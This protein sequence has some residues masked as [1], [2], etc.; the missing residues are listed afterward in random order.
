[1][2]LHRRQL[3]AGAAAA[4]L[5]VSCASTESA[6]ADRAPTDSAPAPA[7][8]PA[9]A[10]LPCTLVLV[11]HTEKEKA[12]HGDPELSRLGKIRAMDFARTFGSTGVTV[13]LHSEFKR[14][15]DTLAPLAAQLGIQS[16]VIEAADEDAL[17]ARIGAASP[18]DVIAVAGHS[19]TIPS[20][21]R[22]FGVELPELDPPRKGM[23]HGFLPSSAY[24]RAHV[25]VPGP[26]GV[27]LVELRYGA[28]VALR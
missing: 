7:E 14:T 22:R 12:D 17:I 2:I 9:T 23:E 28:P 19:N 8:G 26:G 4:L 24:D 21:A 5:A 18:D 16:E 1:M 11:R 20:I 25:L 13:L 6:P 10:P 27:R 3:L 15:R